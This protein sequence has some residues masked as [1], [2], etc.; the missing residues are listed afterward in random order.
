MKASLKQQTLI[1]LLFAVN[2]LFSQVTISTNT[3]ASSQLSGSENGIV[4]QNGHTLTITG[5]NWQFNANKGITVETGGHL[6]ISGNTTLDGPSTT[7][8]SGITAVGDY[9]KDQYHPNYWPNPQQLN[10]NS[11]WSGQLHP[12]QT[13]VK[14]TGCTIRNAIHAVESTLGAVVRVKGC[15]FLENYTCI[16]IKRYFSPS[17]DLKDVNASYVMDSEFTWTT[18]NNM[19]K[20]GIY[21]QQVRGVNIGGCSFESNLPIVNEANHYLR[22]EGIVVNNASF[23]LTKSGDQWCLDDDECKTVCY[24][25]SALSKTNSF[26]NLFRAINIS[27]IYYIPFS[28]TNCNFENNA[29]AIEIAYSSDIAIKDNTFILNTTILNTLFE[30]W[31]INNYRAYFINTT[32]TQRF[33]IRENSFNGTGNNIY[34]VAVREC[35]N[36]QSNI[37]ANTI[38]HSNS[39][40]IL[41]SEVRGIYLDG[42]CKYIYINCNSFSNQ[43]ADI[44]VDMGANV[45][46]ENYYLPSSNYTSVR[47]FNPHKIKLS[48]IFSTQIPNRINIAL[49]IPIGTNVNYTNVIYYYNLIMNKPTVITNTGYSYFVTKDGN[50]DNLMTDNC[51]KSCSQLKSEIIPKGKIRIYPNPTDGKY[52]IIESN[53]QIINN[54]SIYNALG[55]LIYQSFNSSNEIRPNLSPGVYFVKINVHSQVYNEK[56]IVK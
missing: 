14:L 54:I 15:I 9:T 30:N 17:T 20:I 48:N 44:F 12:H 28:I 10:S 34:S 31:I 6:V 36:D 46:T 45:Y 39:S 16:S 21:L 41:S 26:N 2:Q 19:N 23:Y 40:N 55:K 53:H 29:T 43:G 24:S 8:W 22:G 42:N 38:S 5:G 50:T 33:T 18:F 52:I 4:I 1:C 49:A 32:E 13:S 37:L 56:I 27:N 51:T 35:G 3:S 11:S 25:N 47:M 7:K